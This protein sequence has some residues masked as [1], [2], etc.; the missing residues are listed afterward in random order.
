MS[1]SNPTPK[2][3]DVRQATTLRNRTTR[4][5]QTDRVVIWP[6]V[7]GSVVRAEARIARTQADREAYAAKREAQA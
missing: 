4:N 1:K 5:A 2:R 6:T 3:C 7:V